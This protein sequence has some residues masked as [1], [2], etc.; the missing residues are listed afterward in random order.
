MLKLVKFFNSM[1]HAEFEVVVER[2][3]DKVIALFTAHP[4]PDFARDE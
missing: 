3:K 4:Y 2:Y 1:L